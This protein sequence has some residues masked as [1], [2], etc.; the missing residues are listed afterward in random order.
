MF[1]LLLKIRST[2][3]Q[4]DIATIAVNQPFRSDRHHGARSINRRHPLLTS[5]P[6]SGTGHGARSA[7][8]EP[9]PPNEANSARENAPNEANSHV[10]APS[11]ERRDGP[12]EFRIDTP[13]VERKP[14]GIGIT[15]KV[16]VDPDLLRPRS[17]R[18]ST[19]MDLSPI[20]G[21]Q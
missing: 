12:K 4:L 3:D 9:E 7:I 20:F 13:H 21:E 8:E 14:G 18:N 6:H 11:A 17:G 15:G 16:K 1:D 2:G 19:L 10:Q 5:S